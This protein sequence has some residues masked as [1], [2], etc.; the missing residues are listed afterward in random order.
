MPS[1]QPIAVLP[2]NGFATESEEEPTTEV[3]LTMR[4]AS[5]ILINCNVNNTVD[6]FNVGHSLHKKMLRA[7][8]NLLRRQDK[9]LIHKMMKE[10]DEDSK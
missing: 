8:E 3:A 5:L 6:G 7:Q 1:K 2:W 10:S 4:E 9:Y